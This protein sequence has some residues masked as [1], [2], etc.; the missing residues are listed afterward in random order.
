MNLKKIWSDPVWSKVISVIIIASAGLLFTYITAKIENTAFQEELLSFLNIKISLWLAIILFFTLTAFVNFSKK[1]KKQFKYDNETLNLDKE[2][3]EKLK[4]LLPQN[5]SV[6]QFRSYY[7]FLGFEFD[8][9]EDFRGFEE[10]CKRSDFD[11]FHPT[12]ENLKRDLLNSIKIFLRN[13]Y[14]KTKSKD[15]KMRHI[16]PPIE[17]NPEK[18][19]E[20]K[21]EFERSAE[22]LIVKYDELIKSGRQLLKI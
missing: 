10:Y 9:I 11:F 17:E 5:G 13:F 2:M 14:D 4:S 6:N 20:N 21:K 7:T 22:N 16:V 12:L 8:D 18:H 1:R 15:D 3:F 19:D